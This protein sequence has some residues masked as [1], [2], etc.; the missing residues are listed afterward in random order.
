MGLEDNTGFGLSVVDKG[1]VIEVQQLKKKD[2][3]DVTIKVPKGVVVFY[4][5]S[6]PYG[7]TVEF[8]NVESEIEVSTVHSGVE[9]D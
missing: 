5:H 9:P 4:T 7:K 3:P 1:G 6:S 8:K 2:G